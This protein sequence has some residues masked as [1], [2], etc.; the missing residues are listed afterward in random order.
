MLVTMPIL[1]IRNEWVF[2]KRRE[3]ADIFYAY[4]NAYY[5][6]PDVVGDILWDYHKMMRHWW[7]WDISKMTVNKI[8]YKE[9]CKWYAECFQN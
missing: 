8:R 1:I 5:G 6:I 9:M 7:I 2:K 3:F 4:K